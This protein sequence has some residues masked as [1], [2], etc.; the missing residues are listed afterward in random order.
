[1]VHQGCV[2]GSEEEFLATAL[3]FIENGLASG[4][5]VL[6][7]TTRA[8]IA[9]LRDALGP[10]SDLLS[11]VESISFGFR[12]PERLIALDHYW[13]EQV[14]LTDSRWIRVLAEPIWEGR[15]KREIAAWTYMESSFTVLFAHTNL[16]MVCPYDSRLMP[17]QIIAD[18]MRTHPELVQGEQ[19]RASHAYVHPTA[20]IQQRMASP[21]PSLPADPMGDRFTAADLVSVRDQAKSYAHRLS[22]PRS[23]ALDLVFAVNEI[24][25]NVVLHS[26]GTGSVWFWTEEEEL[27]CEVTDDAH[28]SNALDPFAGRPPAL[29]ERGRGLWLVRQLCDRVH[30]GSVEGRTVVRI[31]LR[32]HD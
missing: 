4:E 6:A 31:H 27:I 15:S 28:R 13:R 10:R 3:P 32:I 1:M 23:R 2:Y 21:G 17:H 19:V 16:W 18:S 20:F 11:C 22:L 7:A 12:P 8:N 26:S 24:A 14:S 25:S 5:P 9:L 29:N 30:I